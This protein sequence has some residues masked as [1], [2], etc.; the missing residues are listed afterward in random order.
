MTAAENNQA[1]W[2]A[3]SS[4]FEDLCHSQEEQLTAMA[5]RIA[6]AAVPESAVAQGARKRNRSEDTRQ[7]GTEGK[8][9]HQC[10]VEMVEELKNKFVEADRQLVQ[11]RALLS[12]HLVSPSTTSAARLAELEASIEEALQN[13]KTSVDGSVQADSNLA[14]SLHT[15]VAGLQETAEHLKA[16][17]KL[18]TASKAAFQARASTLE[19]EAATL[20]TALDTQQKANEAMQTDIEKKDSS[21]ETTAKT[22]ASLN[23]RYAAT[24]LFSSCVTYYLH[25]LRY[26]IPY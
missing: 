16:D 4:V 2:K 23:V 14:I 19:S 1:G 20:T 12:S 8:E 24:K 3:R 6:Q 18:A 9:S 11:T 25:N 22:T 13:T 26:C 10:K 7:D 15:K 17:L 5:A 21:L